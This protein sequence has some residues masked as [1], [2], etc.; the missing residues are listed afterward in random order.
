MSN[1]ISWG[2]DVKKIKVS[3]MDLVICCSS[4]KKKKN[5]DQ[6]SSDTVPLN[7]IAIEGLLGVFEENFVWKYHSD[8]L[9]PFPFQFLY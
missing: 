1:L 4:T 5:R 9:S 2:K 8:T 3:E 7:M 6:K